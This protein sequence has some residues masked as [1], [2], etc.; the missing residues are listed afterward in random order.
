VGCGRTTVR[1]Y[2]SGPTRPANGN[3]HARTAELS[4]IERLLADHWSRL[5]LVERLKFFL[6]A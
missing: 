6:K 3:G 4:A 1:K 2:L 5:S